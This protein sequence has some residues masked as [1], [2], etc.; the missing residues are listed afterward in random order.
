MTEPFRVLQIFGRMNRGGAEMRTLDIMRR[1]D[2]EVYHLEF[3]ALSG[4]PGEL[5]DEIHRLG[6]RVHPV[7]L[8]PLFVP[9]FLRLL[10]RRR[11]HA[12][13]SH[14]YY[15][16]GFI[17]KLAARAG[18]PVRIAHFRSCSDGARPTL[19]RMGRNALLRHWIGDH[20]THIVAV[21]EGALA[22]SW[23]PAWRRDPRCHVLHN[24]LDLPAFLG[25]EPHPEAAAGLKRE[26]GVPGDRTLYIHVGRPVTPKNH[27]RL[28]DVFA[29][30]RRLDPRAHLVLVGGPREV[31][32]GLLAGHPRRAEI[33]GHA[34]LLGTR[35]DV[36]RLLK[37]ADLLLFPSLWEGL[38]GVVLEACGAGTPTLATD[39]PG[40]REVARDFSIVRSLPLSDG[41]DRWARA[42]VGLATGPSDERWE[43]EEIERAFSR[44]D[45]NID[46]CVRRHE[47]IWRGEHPG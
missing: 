25:L 36:P 24:G 42:A 43:G 19:A 46:E 29:A 30:I 45:F 1:T 23:S 31:L 28:L 8:G 32:R 5:D 12:V 34:S 10:T 13:H 16:S 6:G 3:A 38:P 40:V 44:S 18:V 7:A 4:L 47:T 21:G 15:S 2:R 27:P 39:L 35:S 33:E 41:D 11:Y 9:R 14:V 22:A 17:L 20:A 37:A 26:L